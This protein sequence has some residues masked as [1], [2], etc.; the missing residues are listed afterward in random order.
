MKNR[1]YEARI[2]KKCEVRSV[3]GRR[4]AV[5]G[6]LPRQACAILTRSHR[7]MR[8]ASRWATILRLRAARVAPAKQGGNRLLPPSGRGLRFVNKSQSGRGAPA[9]TIM[10]PSHNKHDAPCRYGVGFIILHSPQ[11]PVVALRWQGVSC[12]FDHV[13]RVYGQADRD[14]AATRSTGYAQRKQSLPYPSPFRR[15]RPPRPKRKGEGASG[16]A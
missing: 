9:S 2:L 4:R 3:T 14:T 11:P 10:R 8:P 16:G 1:P 12:G 6:R 5:R 13:A 15:R 7:K